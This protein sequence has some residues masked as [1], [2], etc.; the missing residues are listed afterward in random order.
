MNKNRKIWKI[1]LCFAVVVCVASLGVFGWYKYQDYKV[2]KAR[3]ATLKAIESSEFTGET[4]G[5]EPELPAGIKHGQE[6]D[7]EKLQKINDEI[8][9]WI[10]VPGTKIDYPVAQSAGADDHYLKYNFKNEPEFAGCIYTEKKN[11]KDFTDPNTV[12]YGHNMKNGSMFQNLHKFEDEAFFDKNTEVYIY[13]PEKTYTYKIFAAY[14]YDDRHL[15]KAY[16]FSK[17]KVF[18]NYLKNVL[19]RRDMGSNIRTSQEVTQKDKIITLSTCVGGQPENRYLVQ[20]VLTNE[21]DA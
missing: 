9:A 2:Q 17:E 5:K 7:F 16:D 19:H 21:R 10:Y 14:T 4:D 1:V 11:R 18:S 6:I 13:T 20:A 8:Y 15:L 3:E 12:V